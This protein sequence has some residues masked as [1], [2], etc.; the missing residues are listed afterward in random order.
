MTRFNSSFAQPFVDFVAWKRA[1]DIEYK[2]GERRLAY[3]DS[4]LADQKVESLVLTKQ[5]LQDY[6]ALLTP[7]GEAA[8]FTRLVVVLD[9]ARYYQQI[10]HTSAVLET[11]PFKKPKVGRSFLFSI[12]HIHSLIQV[13][14]GLRPGTIMSYVMVTLIGLLY[15]TGMRI[16]E[17]L[18]LTLEDFQSDPYRLFIANSK[19]GKDRWVVLKDSTAFA[20]KAYLKVRQCFA[21]EIHDG[22]FFLNQRGAAL[23]YKSV[24]PCFRGL[25]DQC[26]IGPDCTG[27][28]PRL[29]ALRHTFAVN[30]LVQWYR[31]GLNVNDQ[32]P[33]LVT[34]MGHVDLAS[35]QVYLQATPELRSLASQRFHDYAF[36]EKPCWEVDDV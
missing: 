7:R 6:Q 29:H 1:Q 14:R 28:R 13:A 8:R 9:F 15:T 16:G 4:F 17:A 34:Y 24:Q 25:L 3:F 11:M 2:T 31:Q 30:C 22:P 32:L 12:D 27:A 33:G 20:L 18:R 19:F 36:A 21:R 10:V 26:E 5:H 23:S 35:T